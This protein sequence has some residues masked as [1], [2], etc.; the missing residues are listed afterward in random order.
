MT[1][2]CK[3]ET[4]N[5]TEDLTPEQVRLI[6]FSVPR[7]GSVW[8]WQIACDVLGDGVVKTH[9]WLDLPGVPVIATYRDVRDCIISHW[10][11]RHPDEVERLGVIPKERLYWI[12]ARYLITDWRLDQFGET[13]Q[14]VAIQYE[15][16][17]TRPWRLFDT[18]ACLTGCAPDKDEARRILD[19]RSIQN[20]RAIC[21]TLREGESHQKLFLGHVHEGAAGTWRQ[22]VDEPTAKLINRL[23]R[24][25]LEKMGYD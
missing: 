21:A 11:Y 15:K 2:Y 20:N 25:W 19:K 13:N 8:V 10:R 12:L 1:T 17:I 9:E 3:S 18:I 6:T 16:I 22:F 24:P 14:I 7:S 23:C 4:Y 5:S